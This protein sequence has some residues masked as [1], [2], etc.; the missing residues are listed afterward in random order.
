MRGMSLIVKTITNI[1]VGFMFIYGL[2]IILHG[3]LTPGGGFAGGVI[4]AGAFVLKILAFGSER[5]AEKKS[6]T[7]ASIF[8]SIGGLLFIGIAMSALLVAG[9]FFLNFLP[10]GTPFHLLSAGI[11]P[12]C[13]IAIS[14]KVG[15]GLFSIFLALGAMK[16]IMED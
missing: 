9:T 8:E 6:A 7:R 4:V 1:T 11:I 14:I 2:Y 15:A 3:H 13:N 5:S 12:F 10:K 16:Y